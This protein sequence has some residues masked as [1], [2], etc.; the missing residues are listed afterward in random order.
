[1]TTSSRPSGSKSPGTI[2]AI[3]EQGAD[4]HP[5]RKAVSFE[6]RSLSYAGL[7]RAA[8]RMADRLV[9]GCGVARGDR[10][11]VLLKNT[12]EFIVSFFGI[13]K[14]G[15]VVVPLNY[16]LTP[17]EIRYIANDC[18]VSV[19]ISSGEFREALSGI[20]E[21]LPA[22]RKVLFME[23]ADPGNAAGAGGEA[24]R[25]PACPE[26]TALI[27][28]TSGTTG[29]PKGAVLNHANI[30]SNIAGSASAL[31]VTG[32]DRLLLV[33]PVFHSFT[34]TACILMPLYCG[35]C[36]VMLRSV[37]PF[38]GFMKALLLKRITILIGIPALFNILVG[39]RFPWWARF[40]VRIRV[41]ISGSS[42]L[43]PS[44]LHLWR[45]RR[46]PPLLEGYGL[47]EASP[48][49]SIN[50]YRG[51]AKGGSVG[52]PVPG[53]RV[54]IL[55]EEGGTGEII[56]SGPNVMKGYY[57]RPEDTKKAL[58]DGWLRTGDMGRIDEDGY[59]F[60]VG[61]KSDMILVHGMNVYPREIEEVLYAHPRVKEAAVV[62]RQDE[63]HGEIPVAF[64][65]MEGGE[66]GDLR[67]LREHCARQL[68]KYKVPRKFLFL[69]SLPRTG[70]GKI[71]KRELRKM[72]GEL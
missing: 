1:M 61:R 21:K 54:G 72:A 27:I 50:P 2:Q 70:T 17:P 68:A 19:I 31:E 64:L 47:S 3:L 23:D 15:A 7:D 6:G 30:I 20:F 59:L 14:A 11:A 29:H 9:R 63:K 42:P 43:P 24:P 52:L 12:P 22:L 25:A 18:E 35:A 39:M 55:G 26:D 49:V 67:E 48:V 41:C 5:R 53:V 57:N 32:R 10:V 71:L 28:Y 16:F 13:L 38:T 51:V 58:R 65:S 40:I 45:H 62:G 66:E 8:E 37:Q 46:F 36:I 56:V 33:L 60:I 4:L 34:I 69:D 44:T